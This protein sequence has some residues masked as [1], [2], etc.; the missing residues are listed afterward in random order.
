MWHIKIYN[1]FFSSRQEISNHTM[2]FLSFKIYLLRSGMWTPD[3]YFIS[4]D[5]VGDISKIWSRKKFHIPQEYVNCFILGNSLQITCTV[6][7]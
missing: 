6:T 3:F 2:A 7:A 4:E 5:F 1:F